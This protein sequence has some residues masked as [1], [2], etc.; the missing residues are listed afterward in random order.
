MTIAAL[1]APG[2]IASPRRA[3][4][5]YI[6]SSGAPGY[7]PC[8][9][10]AGA[11]PGDLLLASLIIYSQDAATGTINEESGWTLVYRESNGAG[12]FIIV[13]ELWACYRGAGSAE[14]T[15]TITGAPPDFYGLAMSCFRNVS[16]LYGEQSA[17]T[18]NLFTNPISFTGLSATGEGYLFGTGSCWV[19]SI[20]SF[21][22]MTSEAFSGAANEISVWVL[23]V[24][25]GGVA[26]QDVSGTVGY[27]A[28]TGGLVFLK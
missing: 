26:N 27:D 22:T 19:S 17:G 23:P 16:S 18:Q 12:D 9:E 2:I 5:V 1:A 20:A 15:A 28:F 10:P 6:S 24:S 4:P 3:T 8:P 7:Y 14:Y 11:E 21:G 13:N 25:N